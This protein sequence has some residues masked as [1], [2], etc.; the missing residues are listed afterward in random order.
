[1]FLRRKVF[2]LSVELK[3]VFVVFCREVMKGMRQAKRHISVLGIGCNIVLWKGHDLGYGIVRSTRL[4]LNFRDF[5]R[6]VLIKIRC[7]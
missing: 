5:R 1:M 3:E 2:R 6:K 4:P 7:T